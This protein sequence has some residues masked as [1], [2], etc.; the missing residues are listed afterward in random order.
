MIVTPR[1]CT[2]AIIANGC[3]VELII[4][5][6]HR[7]AY[8]NGVRCTW[9]WYDRNIVGW[10]LVNCVMGSAHAP[11]KV[12]RP[13]RSSEYSLLNKARLHRGI[14]PSPPIQNVD[15]S[16]PHPYLWWFPSFGYGR[17]NFS[18]MWIVS[19]S[20][21]NISR[22]I[23]TCIARTLLCNNSIG[24]IAC[25][26]LICTVV[27][28]YMKRKSAIKEVSNIYVLRNELCA[29]KLIS[30]P[31]RISVKGPNGVHDGG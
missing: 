20:I 29:Q 17:S 23:T 19:V 7:K 31:S 6:W 2:Q 30:N 25:Y 26:I 27:C 14:E 10:H 11:W 18:F 13:H 4:R 1:G 9:K 28:W 15:R 24:L 12:G 5:K 8:G 21:F 22:A 16:D 3:C